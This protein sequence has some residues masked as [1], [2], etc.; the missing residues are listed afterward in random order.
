M[1]KKTIFTLC[2]AFVSSIFITGCSNE[3]SSVSSSV[4]GSS[5]AAGAQSY[6]I[7]RS[8]SSAAAQNSLEAVSLSLNADKKSDRYDFDDDAD[9]SLLYFVDADNITHEVIF[10]IKGEARR[11]YVDDVIY[12][13]GGYILAEVEK[14]ARYNGSDNYTSGSVTSKSEKLILINSANGDIK[15]LPVMDGC[16]DDIEQ[17]EVIG[18][19]G[20]AICEDMAYT[21]DIASLTVKERIGRVGDDAYDD[22]ALVV[23]PNGYVAATTGAGPSSNKTELLNAPSGVEINFDADPAMYEFSSL[24]QTGDEVTF[25]IYAGGDRQTQVTYA[26]WE[27]LLRNSTAMGMYYFDQFIFLFGNMDYEADDGKYELETLDKYFWQYDDDPNNRSGYRFANFKDGDN[28]IY[29]LNMED[30]Y[31]I[32]DNEAAQ[33]NVKIS[34]AVSEISIDD[35]GKISKKVVAKAPMSAKGSEGFSGVLWNRKDTTFRYFGKQMAFD[36]ESF[37]TVD[38]ENKTV[39]KTPWTIADA[40][41]KKLYNASQNVKNKNIYYGSEGIVYL[42]N[43]KLTFVGYVSENPVKSFTP[44]SGCTPKSLS[45]AGSTVFY[46]CGRNTYSI[47]FGETTFRETPVSATGK[48]IGNIIEMKNQEGR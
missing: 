1:V 19:T 23:F 15:A 47:D 48:T 36:N 6:F 13:G 44:S 25:D 11:A 33:S 29:V 18:G 40:D 2:T 3:S 12:A 39:M 35:N 24:P 32:N 4:S 10:N 31:I 22:A 5:N 41:Y 30:H 9:G 7:A 42:D 14:Y 45:M 8:D 20:Y 21:V 46:N 16:G 38:M 43:N 34:V 17:F 37:Y 28:K 26:Q 27:N